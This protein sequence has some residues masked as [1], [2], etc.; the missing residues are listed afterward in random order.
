MKKK[1]ITALKFKDK[2]EGS[3]V[4][5]KHVGNEKI[6]FI[7]VFVIFT[8]HS[9][10]LIF[11]AAYMFMNSFKDATEY[12]DSAIAF[13]QA[14]DY[15]NYTEVF[16]SF[17][18]GNDTFFTML[19]NSVW[20][21]ALTALS[22]VLMPMTVGYCLARYNFPGKNLLYSIVLFSLTIPLVGSGAAGLKLL[23]ALG[24]YDSP[25]NKVVNLMSGF[26]GSFLVFYGFFKSVSPAYSEAAKVDGAGPYTIYF[27]IILPQ[28]VPII[29]TYLIT[30]SIAA[31][32]D[33]ESVL[34]YFPSWNTISSGL[35]SYKE[36]N[37]RGDFPLYYAGLVVATIPALT[38]FA[39]FSKRIMTSLSV[40]GIKG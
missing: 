9:L 18:V 3:S 1:N 7:I 6:L 16:S 24:I 33:Y 28:A 5:S 36:N 22:G 27:K 21:V 13:P 25:L 39:V 20:Y 2:D 4:L 40:G 38:V 11:P 32:N 31:W 26:T 37:A 23:G 8:I 34:L 12:F 30:N 29:T 15:K 17:R 10:S 35:F 14:F 19:F